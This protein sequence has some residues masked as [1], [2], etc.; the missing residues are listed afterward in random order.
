MIKKVMLVIIILVG[1]FTDVDLLQ[2][3]L[4]NGND[5]NKCDYYDEESKIGYDGM[6]PYLIKRHEEN[7]I[8]K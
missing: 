3:R 7:D 6:I 1:F 5:E 4:P 8:V 2:K